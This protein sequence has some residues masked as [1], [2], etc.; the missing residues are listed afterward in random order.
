MK[1]LAKFRL[2]A[3]RRFPTLRRRGDPLLADRGS[4]ALALLLALAGTGVFLVTGYLRPSG[5]ARALRGAVATALHQQP[6]KRVHLNAGWLTTTALRTG[7]RWI[8]MPEEARV[9]VGSIH[10]VEVGVY[11]MPRSIEGQPGRVLV[12][13][14]RKMTSRGWE[15]AVGVVDGEQVVAVYV[16]SGKVPPSRFKVCVL[17]L[18][19]RQLVIGTAKGDLD[20]A[21]DLLG[22]KLHEEFGLRLGHKLW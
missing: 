15:R 21:L 7:T 22:R 10:G 6:G 12:E 4:V 16:P 19:G 5:E 13:S 2:A 20:R 17:V 1:H 18:D 11:E 8:E 14:D 3:S 9:A